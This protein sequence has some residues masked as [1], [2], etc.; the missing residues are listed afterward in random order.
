MGDAGAHL[1]QQHDCWVF[2]GGFRGLGFFFHLGK[3]VVF[4]SSATAAVSLLRTD[5]L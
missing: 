3:P 4:I 2:Y 1:T 5:L